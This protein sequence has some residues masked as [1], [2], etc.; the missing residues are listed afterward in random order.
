M[1]NVEDFHLLLAL[2]ASRHS[3]VIPIWDITVNVHLCHHYWEE[4]TEVRPKHEYYIEYLWDFFLTNPTLVS[5]HF[6]IW[7]NELFKHANFLLMIEIRRL[8]SIVPFTYSKLQSKHECRMNSRFHFQ[9]NST[10]T[11]TISTLNLF[12]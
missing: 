8:F 3:Y 10:Y 6:W 1:W 5:T 4:G 7:K 12:L 2:L 9:L 11:A